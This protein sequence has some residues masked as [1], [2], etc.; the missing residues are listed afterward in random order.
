[1]IQNPGTGAADAN[2]P[3]PGNDTSTGQAQT[4]TVNWVEQGQSSG[5]AADTGG[6][7]CCMQVEVGHA[8]AQGGWGSGSGGG[9]LV[10]KAAGSRFVFIAGFQFQPLT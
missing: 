7:C 1:M 2:S 3:E 10:I 8:Q 4:C 6:Y 5:D 9:G